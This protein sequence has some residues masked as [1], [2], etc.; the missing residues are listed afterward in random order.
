MKNKSKLSG[1]A[2]GTTG[3]SP[4]PADNDNSGVR[5]SAKAR[6]AT[7]K[8]LKDKLPIGVLGVQG[9]A[10]GGGNDGRGDTGNDNEAEGEMR[11]LGTAGSPDDNPD[12]QNNSAGKL[13]G[14]AMKLFDLFIF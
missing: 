5:M 12:L 3:G 2:G 7:E 8:L 14:G 4:D 11:V 9:K 10:G 1:P 13:P 6:A